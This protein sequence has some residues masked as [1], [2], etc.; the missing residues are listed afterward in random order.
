MRVVTSFTTR[1]LLALCL[2]AGT[3]QGHIA[4]THLHGI[5]ST[6][7][8]AT[9]AQLPAE[10]TCLLCD[11]AGHSPAA[12]PPSAHG[13]T[14][15]VGLFSSPVRAEF[16]VLLSTTASHHWLSRGPPPV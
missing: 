1:L 16:V 6:E 11:V 15:D 10:A 13:T 3:V 5:R 2:L 9:A 4:Q 14:A 7:G 8:A 12:A